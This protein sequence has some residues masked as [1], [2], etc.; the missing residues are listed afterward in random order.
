MSFQ[1]SYKR[2]VCL[3]LNSW[4]LPQLFRLSLNL[5]SFSATLTA[6]LKVQFQ[7]LFKKIFE[8]RAINIS[9][10]FPTIDARH[11]CCSVAY[12][13]IQ[14]KS[15]LAIMNGV[16]CY[17]ELFVWPLSL[18]VVLKSDLVVVAIL[19]NHVINLACLNHYD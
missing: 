16:C 6:S 13:E 1:S 11:I 3:Q 7:T 5:L 10:F 19:N 15:C 8:C 18:V 9:E 17:F 14:V 2:S 12:Y 4:S